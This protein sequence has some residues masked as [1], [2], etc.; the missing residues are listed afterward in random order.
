MITFKP[1]KAIRPKPELAEKVASL[2]YDVMDREEAKNMAENNP[3]SFLHISRPEID[4]DG[5]V[6]PYDEP[7]YKKATEN[8]S[9]FIENGTMVQDDEPRFYIYRQIMQGRVQT[10]IAG[11]ASVDEYLNGSIKKHELTREEKEIDRIKNFDYC[12]AHTEP[13]FLT[14]KSSCSLNEII[15]NWMEKNSPLYHF[16]SEDGIEHIVWAVTDKKVNRDIED[17]FSKK[18]E[19]F[20]IADGHH[21]SASSVKVG[22]QRRAQCSNFTGNEEFNHFMAVAFP[23]TD[24][25]IMDY[26]R[27]VKDLNGYT[28]HDFITKLLETFHVCISDEMFKPNE[29]HTFGMYLNKRWYKLVA[30]DGTFDPENIIGSMDLSILQNKRAA[31]VVGN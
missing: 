8:L 13:V 14:Y 21:R 18:L 6:D 24:L 16:Q 7:V 23:D 4:L 1:F 17:E 19:S 28:E 2:P 29:K 30:K 25:C 27:V 11:C 5:S 15:G 31:A 20:Y 10:G 9:R 3:Y 12:N 26:N 22:L